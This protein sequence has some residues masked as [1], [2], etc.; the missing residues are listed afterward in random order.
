M[1]IHAYSLKDRDKEGNSI[2]VFIQDRDKEAIVYVYSI[3][4]RDKEITNLIIETV[5]F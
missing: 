4:D 1:C 2:C 5:A 3:K